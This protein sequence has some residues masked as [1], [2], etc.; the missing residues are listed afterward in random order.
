[1]EANTMS[2]VPQGHLESLLG[3]VPGQITSPVNKVI[4]FFVS[5]EYGLELY[6][7]FHGTM[8]MLRHLQLA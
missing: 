3:E 6:F 1:M 8:T 5:S 7:S 4:F 2:I